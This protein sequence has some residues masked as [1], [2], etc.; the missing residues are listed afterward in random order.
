VTHPPDALAP[1]RRTTRLLA[2]ALPL[3][4][5]AAALARAAVVG[6]AAL[7]IAPAVQ[8]ALAGRVIAVHDGDTLSIRSASGLTTRVRLFGIDAPER[9][10]AYGSA[11]RRALAM[12]VAGREVRVVERGRDSYGRLLGTV[13]LEAQDVNARLVRDG[14]A[15]VYERFERDAALLALQA[16]AKAARRGLWRDPHPEPPW[17]WRARE[18]ERE[19]EPAAWRAGA[20]CTSYA[21]PPLV[22]A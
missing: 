18:R 9:G 3:T 2:P 17:R 10:Q 12:L 20:A 6:L 11:S 19:R 15:W 22:L 14:Y 1:R 7:A 16:E 4:E 21:G 8:A 5:R 13:H